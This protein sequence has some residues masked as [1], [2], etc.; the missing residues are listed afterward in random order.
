[1]TKRPKAN[2]IILSSDNSQAINRLANLF[3]FK[4]SHIEQSGLIA[5]DRIIYI[6]SAKKEASR[7]LL[8][9]FKNFG[10]DYNPPIFYLQELSVRF[11]LIN[12]K[13]AK[14]KFVNDLLAFT[15]DQDTWEVFFMSNKPF[16]MVFKNK[17]TQE[18]LAFKQGINQSFLDYSLPNYQMPALHYYCIEG[19]NSAIAFVT[20]KL[21]KTLEDL[22][23]K[24]DLNAIFELINNA[25]LY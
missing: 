2:F 19:Q 4:E 25:L 18:K 24:N 10:K 17:K 11:E 8:K 9:N 13:V 12:F 15:R 7:I 5:G 3:P 21:K 14:E 6:L 23:R 20:K 22:D 16:F 1:M